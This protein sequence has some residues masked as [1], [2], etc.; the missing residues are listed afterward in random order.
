MKFSYKFSPPRR[1]PF[2]VLLH[3]SD[4]SYELMA[5]DGSTFHT[6]RNHVLLYYPEESGIF[7]FLRQYHSTS[8][9]LNN[10]DTSCY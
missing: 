1:G 3:L 7:P 10:S 9:L 4:V 6:H 2:R 5:Q 8:S